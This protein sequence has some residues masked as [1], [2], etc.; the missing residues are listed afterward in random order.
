MDVCKK[1]IGV[2]ADDT[3]GA[4]DIGIMFTKAGYRSCVL[5]LE[6][7]DK[8][9][10]EGMD[11][12]IIDT[13]SRLD[14]P[15]DAAAKVRRATKLLQSLPCDVYH[16]KTCSVFRGNIGAE[17]D[18]MQET[19][20]VDCSMVVLGF[21]KN[22]RTTIGGIHYLNGQ[23]LEDSQFAQDPI[24]PADTSVLADIIR[25]QSKKSVGNIT[26]AD[27]DRGLCFVCGRM[28]TLRR[29]NAYIVFDVRDQQDLWLIAQ[30]IKEEPS[31]CGSSA[32]GEELPRAYNEGMPFTNGIKSL[33]H[34]VEDACGVLLLSGSLT[35]QTRSQIAYLRQL[36]C[37]AWE[38]DTDSVFD[39]EAL[40]EH[41]AEAVAFGAAH[42]KE[43]RDVLIHTANEPEAVQRT[44]ERAYAHGWND[45]AVGKRISGSMCAVAEQI[46]EQTGGRKL[47]VAGGDTSAA[48]AKGLRVK[49]MVI[50]EEIEPG[51]PTMYGD[52]P[53]GEL[54]MV[55][56]SGSFGSDS[57]LQQSIEALKALQD[58]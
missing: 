9:D 3:T 10:A 35:V 13:N 45:E 19:L 1:R 2:V 58:G 52:T 17:F 54:L 22:G 53:K 56:K 48:V 32:I 43:G 25:K 14:T 29:Q 41:I 39:E 26:V 33:L 24:H 44:K 7:M 36:G 18:A 34:P 51:V 4:N 57:F 8:P 40:K 15:Q 20:G 28:E 50:L 31:L 47:V 5:P 6:F 30:A 27:L 37:K 12:I 38:F 21:P 16:N 49:K 23:L 46:F 55:L 11:V 42:L